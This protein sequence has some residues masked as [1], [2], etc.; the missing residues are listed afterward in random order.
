M[1]RNYQIEASYFHSTKWKFDAT[2]SESRKT[3]CKLHSRMQIR[4]TKKLRPKS[5]DLKTMLMRKKRIFFRW[6]CFWWTLFGNKKWIYFE[7]GFHLKF[8]ASHGWL[9]EGLSM[10]LFGGFFIQWLCFENLRRRRFRRQRRRRLN[11][12]KVPHSGLERKC[13]EGCKHVSNFTLQ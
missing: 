13:N 5:P 8:I 7:A 3:D 12:T 2:I 4:A 6:K 1:Y 9:S 10:S 11:Q